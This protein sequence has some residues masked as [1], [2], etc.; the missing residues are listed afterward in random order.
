VDY[1]V[2]ARAGA[3][4][5]YAWAAWQVFEEHPW[6]GVGLGGSGLYLYDHLPEWSR[7]E[8]RDVAYALSPEHRPV[9]NP[10]SMYPRLL[11]ETGIVGLAAFVAFVLGVLARA[12]GLARR[13]EPQARFVGVAGWW[14]VAAMTVRWFTQDAL[15]LPTFWIVAGIVLAFAAVSPAPAEPVP[16]A[17]MDSA[18]DSAAHSGHPRNWD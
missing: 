8:L 11:A 4:L 14:L 17:P 13:R 3:R 9:L 1:V 16:P 7:T 6:L 5:A 15:S 12:E 2:Q 10:K 18:P